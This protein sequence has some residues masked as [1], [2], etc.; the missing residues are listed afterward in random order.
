[1]P[2]PPANG[3]RATGQRRHWRWTLVLIA[4][5]WSFGVVVRLYWIHYA[6]GV[7]GGQWHGVA[8]TNNRDSYLFGC[9]LQ[10]AHLGMHQDNAMVPG[11][12]DHGMITVLPYLLLVVLPVTIDQL[13]L[14][15]PVLI[16][17]LLAVP[18]V[19]IGRLERRPGWG[20]AA[21]L[22]AVVANCY[23]N[24]TLAGYFDTD[25]F[26]VTVPTLALFFL[27]GVLR[28]QDLFWVLAA[29]VTLLVY[30]FFYGPG[31][32]I[33]YAMGMA[34]F[35][36]VIIVHR[37]TP[38]TW[39]TVILLSLA[40]IG[41]PAYRGTTLAASP[42]W[43]G[44][45]LA[46]VCGACVLLRQSWLR[47]RAL[48][49]L[50]A[51]CLASFLLLA[52]PLDMIRARTT[53]LRGAQR[54]AAAGRK[55]ASP[56]AKAAGRPKARRRLHFQSTLTTVRETKAIPLSVVATRTSGS[57]LGALVA[58]V[59]YGLLCWKRREM[60]VA[61]PLVGLGLF[62]LVGGL[63][64]TIFAVPIAALSA[65]H[66]LDVMAAG[67]ARLT[68]TLG[69]GPAAAREPRRGQR[70][71]RRR[72]RQ[73]PLAGEKAP[74]G[75]RAGSTPGS[76]RSPAGTHRRAVAGLV[77]LGTA[78]L[79]LPNL[80]HVVAY[81]VG[82]VLPAPAVAALD[83]VGRE[84]AA[85][86]FVITWWDYGSAVWYY[87]GCQTLNSPASNT[88]RDNFLVSQ[89]LA[90][91]SQRQAAHLCRIAAER[92]MTRRWRNFSVIQ[93]ILRQKTD[94][95]EFLA[96]VASGD[97]PLPAKSREVF[98]FLPI[99]LLK[100][101]PAIRSFS[102][103]DLVS[104]KQGRAPVFAITPG[105]VDGNRIALAN[106]IRIDIG[107][108]RATLGRQPFP[109]AAVHV[110]S[111]GGGSK[112]QTRT[113]PFTAGTATHVI[114]LADSGVFLVLD[115]ASFRSTLV[116]LFLFER[117]DRALFEPLALTPTVKV[118]RVKP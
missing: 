116:Q 86:D 44:L 91:P 113:V 7:D 90:T 100:M 16:A 64:F 19:L 56:R 13:I 3:N 93:A 22:L 81:K 8:I 26:S 76:G 36:Y 89:I 54:T 94:P 32:P 10:K 9:I 58:L 17:P 70:R 83:E 25:I 115:D 52:S 72:R 74:S 18:L 15:L 68:L 103:R 69:A 43:G 21:A 24:R 23:Y 4:L 66:G 34:M 98:L 53:Q 31:L 111:Y 45:G 29:S 55:A 11:I 75:G 46:V 41:S 95:A 104:G 27:L 114:C 78:A 12:L 51:V 62:A 50:A 47:G 117:Y 14:Y 63:R 87:S 49:G 6:A 42:W 38:F 80:Q 30:P 39:S 35:A 101:Y 5:A 110:L 65:V 48:V 37:N 88:S 71:R 105:R 112:L 57:Q 79:L 97:Y 33:G 2:T 92:Y 99:E 118:Y 67:I 40:L 108:K 28:T 61:L 82:P 106:G 107:A 102:N 109:L 60:L 85:G 73:S 96:R 84:N 59:G 1:M 77:G 20:F